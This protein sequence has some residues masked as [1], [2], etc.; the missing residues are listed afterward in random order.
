MIKRS[1]NL[2]CMQL[3]ELLD[4]LTFF[5]NVDSSLF[6]KINLILHDS[7]LSFDF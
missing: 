5:V 6:Q 7:L 1:I 3:K 2:A 4:L